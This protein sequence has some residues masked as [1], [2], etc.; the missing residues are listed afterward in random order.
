MKS[1]I[2]RVRNVSNN[3]QYIGS[4]INLNS[5]RSAHFVALRRGTHHSPI[6][7]GAYNKAPKDFVFEVVELCNKESLI[8][9]EQH[10]IDTLTPAY[11]VRRTAGN[12]TYNYSPSDAVRKRQSENRKGKSFHTPLQRAA[13]SAAHKGKVVSKETRMKRARA[14]K[15]LTLEG[16]FVCTYYSIQEAFRKTGINNIGCCLRGLQLKAGGYTWQYVDEQP[17]DIKA[18]SKKREMVQRNIAHRMSK[19]QDARRCPVMQ[20]D[21]A[22]LKVLREFS[23]MREADSYWGGSSNVSAAV[24]G[25]TKTAYGFVWRKKTVNN[26]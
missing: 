21:P 7:Q 18:F 4:S 15:Q 22:T 3:K 14:I 12:H 23:S 24:N 13:I 20:L 1:G 8:V 10:Y 25:K 19:M 2:Y 6:L 16:D 17:A 9:R 26:E 11:N 5:R